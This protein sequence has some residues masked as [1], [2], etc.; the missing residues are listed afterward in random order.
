[1]PD[2]TSPS[3]RPARDGDDREAR[4]GGGAR[5]GDRS[6]GRGRGR[7]RGR[8]HGRGRGQ[9]PGRER[10][11][12][13][14]TR[15]QEAVAARRAALPAPEALHY[16]PELPVSERRD[17]IKALIRDHQVVIVAGETGSGKTT[18]LPKICL[19]LGRGV[20]GMIGH[21]QP[22]RIA[23]RSVAERVSEE[24][25]TELGTLV[26]YQVRFTDTSRQDTLLKVMTDGILLAELQRDRML[27]RYD[28][29]IIDEAHERSLNIDFILG[30]L[31][32]LLPRRP[33]LKVVI[34]SATIDVHRFA[35][36]F[37][38]ADG[39]PAPVIEV[40]GRT[41]P[42][43]VRYRPLQREGPPTKQG[44]ATFVEVDQV[45][46]I[47][48]A[49][50]ELWTEGSGRDGAGEDILVFCSGEREIR[51]ATDALEGMQ[52]P[53]TEVLPLYGR[54][55]AAEQHRVFARHP[56][57]RIVVST[58]VAETSLTVP[59]IR[60]VIDTGTARISRYSQRLKVQRL[61]IEPIS[62]ASAN[63]RA[64]RCGR[65][66]D[67]I[68]IR[69]YSQEDF[70]SRPEFT[71]PEIL[72]TNLASVILQMTNLGLGEIERFPFLEPPDSRQVA[73]GVRLLTE[74][75]A[76]DPTA[77]AHLPRQRITPYGRAIV[78]LP[79]DPRLARMLVEAERNGALK[80]VLVIV[81]ALSIQ[82]VRERPVDQQ[83]R[84]DQLHAR[85]RRV[86]GVP[87]S[88]GGAAGGKNRPVRVQG[89]DG[90]GPK[91]G[92]GGSRGAEPPDRVDSDFLV[93]L[94]LWRYL[95]R[96]QKDL[97]GSAFRR[98][99][100][101][102]FLHYL[103]V[104]EWQDL[105]AQLRQAAK[106]L[107]LQLN[108][109]P[110]DADRV[111]QSLLAGLL[112]H[113]G[114]YDK[115]RRDY[116]GARNARFVLQPGSVL[117]R[118][119]P[120]WVMTAELVETTRL[121]AR[122][123][124]AI[125]PAW[126]EASAQHLVRRSY[127]EPRW[128]RSAAAAVADE[129]VTL[130]GIPLVAGRAVPLGRTDPE[131]ARDLFIRTALVEGDWD[132]R[133]D[134]FH[135]NRRL[136]D[137]LG[138]LEARARRRDILV[139]DETLVEFYDQRIP[140]DVVSGAHFDAWWKKARRTQPHLLTFTEELLVHEEHADAVRGDDFPTSWTQGELN[141]PLTY[142]FEPGADADGVTVHLPVEV[143]NQVQDDG[144]D[145]LVPGMH[146]ELVTALVK[147]LPKDVRRNF[148]PAPD[149]A[150]AALRGMQEAGTVGTV[151][152]DEALAQELTRRGLVRVRATDIEWDRVP[153]HLRMTFRV[154]RAVRPGGDHK[155]GQQPGGRQSGGQGR[156]HRSKGRVEVLG[157]GKD[158]AALQEQ[159]AGQVR[160]TMAAAASGVERTGLTTWP[161]DLDPLPQT[162]SRQVGPRVV[163]GFPALVDTGTAVDVRVLATRSEADRET[164]RGIRRLLLLS[165]TPPWK[166]LLALL[167]NEQKLALG[168]NPH[169][170]VPALLEDALAA[171]VDSVV[172]DLGGASGV[173]TPAQFEQALVAVRQQSVPRVLEIVEA[174]VPILDTA[175]QVSLRLQRLTTPA[176]AD[177][178]TDLRR[179]L[180]RLVRPGFVAEVGHARLPRMVVWLRGMAE[181]LDKGVQD[182]PRDRQRTADVHVVEEELAAFLD[183][184]PPHR[185]QDPDVLDVVWSVQE[186]R[187]SLFAQRLGTAG[188]ISP[189]RIYA[190]MDAAE[191]ATD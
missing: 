77:P 142:Q 134:F 129:R 83:E 149:H 170:S 106:G 79:V 126:V 130:Y 76:I 168:Y 66:A 107:G 166:R 59:G 176:A 4:G 171:A 41:Y 174:L 80:E 62:Q 145:W 120:E 186:L 8:S 108:D 152:V 113:V 26:G 88:E 73:D 147:A 172:A 100:K 6:H 140:A 20:E 138:Q 9:G 190:A 110:A 13:R 177:M 69:L 52:L 183:K 154:E 42:V 12:E 45:T 102:E 34:T 28:T 185:R 156:Q 10:G 31:R 53:G 187:V 5:G 16:P 95:Q 155:G 125:D 55:S 119:N 50:E 96:Q 82:D 48:E 169:G 133:H 67:G 60:Y 98:L 191:D 85:F 137:E 93:L 17:E 128:S 14:H 182:L 25:G 161:A 117:H 32:Q 114:L 18:Q 116:Q 92:S 61:P 122:T 47:C 44:E 57:R 179:Q 173:R 104:R 11:A 86:G 56:G 180:D 135:A 75:Q 63:Q 99:C 150:R 123:N 24:L 146:E 1:M 189:K 91:G 54:L 162:F 35:A 188:P 51:D 81:A 87:R 74:L 39:R 153:D 148:V 70:E 29:L 58:N 121:W 159:L 151:P 90:R 30:Y 40:S 111:H 175:R 37:A 164:T 2:P 118:R 112:S 105:H 163:Q 7:G 178:A 49:V 46:G 65:L 127:S 103:R 181:R 101:A 21:T 165:T 3:P 160:T 27:S 84:A 109:H 43:E 143:L 89:A 167:T 78:A 115:E 139:D 131:T 64:G 157:E 72:R 68:A 94:N 38:D 97:S 36:H 144:F 23:A 33:D 22:R 158:L 184:L 136:V 141:F 124:A 132:T 71:D 19:E 15:R